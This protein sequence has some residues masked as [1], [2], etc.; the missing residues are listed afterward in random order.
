MLNMTKGRLKQNGVHLED[1]EYKTIKF[2]LERGEN[3]ELIPPIQIK[4]M[5]TPDIQ[6]DGVVWEI[7]SPTGDGKHT[8]KHAVSN[9]KHQSTSI[10]ID[11]RRC[12]M[13]DDK[14]VN[15]VLH[16][17]N[18]S[19]RLRRLKIIKKNEELLDFSK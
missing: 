3:V 10:I 4:G 12:K 13:S 19:K 18:L 16:H 9:A 14:A 1:H 2:F 5:S 11:L 15:E 17:F 7:K 8:M 6:I